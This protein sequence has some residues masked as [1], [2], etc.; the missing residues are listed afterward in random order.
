MVKNGLDI[1]SL[2]IGDGANDVAMIQEADVGVGIAG[3]EGRQAAMSSDYAIAQF[4]FL[5]RLVLVHGRWSYRRMAE[6]IS[7][8]FY[9]NM[10]WVWSI[11]WFQIYCN[12]DITYIFEFTYIMM[13]NLFFTSVPVALMGV[14][15]QDVSD[16]VSLAVPQLYRRG[17]ER[18]EWTNT[19]FWLYMFDGVYQSVIVFY[20]PYLAIYTGNPVTQNGLD[21]MERF[22]LGAY[23]AH[24]AVFVINGYIL[25]NTYRWDWIMVLVVAISNLFVF[26][27]TGVYTSFSTAGT[28]A[29]TAKEIYGQASFWACFFIVPVM[30]LAPRFIIKAL[31]KV[32]WPYD[33]DIIR[34]QETMGKFDHLKTPLLSQDNA[35]GNEAKSANSKSSDSSG[36]GKHTAAAPSMDSDLRPFA[37][38][39]PSTATRTTHNQRSQNGSDSTNFTGPRISLDVPMPMR[40]SMDRA[41]PSFQRMRASMDAMRPSFEDV[42]TSANRLSKIES[43]RSGTGTHNRFSRLRGLSLSKSNPNP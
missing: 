42:T 29:G 8:F 17:I 23:I 41:G 2:S 4:R 38:Y 12:F 26:F 33:I 21:M 37:A 1:M 13:F 24:P 32:Y 36:R 7:N 34:E 3:V 40:P 43:T 6:C 20:I 35:N 27:W 28:F 18:L 19:K 31:Q 9:K 11:F 16:K 15:D 25:I 39:A 22:R 30:C 10:V 5:Q 14:L